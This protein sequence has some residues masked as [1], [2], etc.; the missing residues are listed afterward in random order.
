MD[1]SAVFAD[2]VALTAE[3]KD[4]RVALEASPEAF[5]RAVEA[6][7]A[8]LMEQILENA[9]KTILEAAAKGMSTATLYAFN[10][11]DAIDD[12][13]VLFVFKGQRRTAAP[14]PP[15]TPRPLLY[16][17]Q[18]ALRPFTVTHEWDGISGGNR[19]LARW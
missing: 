13:S 9:S 10:G 11:N 15:G 7:R 18:G 17:L 14:P 19:I 1:F 3:A 2:A 4:A 6:V 8:D 5:V 12:V 16:D